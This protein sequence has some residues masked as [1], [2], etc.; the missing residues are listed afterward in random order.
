MRILLKKKHFFLLI[1][2]NQ[3][4]KEGELKSRMSVIYFPS[5]CTALIQPMNKNI[6]RL[7]KFNYKKFL[8]SP[9]LL[10]KKLSLSHCKISAWKMECCYCHFYSVID[11]KNFWKSVWLDCADI[12]PLW[13]LRLLIAVDAA[14]I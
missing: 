5:N 7:T 6:I 14:N 9:L 1:W 10:V 4:R 2:N 11:L 13:E 12:I 3:G 8:L